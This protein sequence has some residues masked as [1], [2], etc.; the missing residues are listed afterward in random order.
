MADKHPKPTADEATKAKALS[1]WEGEGGAPSGRLEPKR[2]RVEEA[3]VSVRLPAEPLDRWRAA[4]PDNPTRSEAIRR[5]VEIGLETKQ[6]PRRKSAAEREV[7]AAFAKRA[8]ETEV[9]RRHGSS[10]QTNKAKAR[11]KRALTDRW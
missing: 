11:Q 5:L 10:D 2:P 7:G 9:D 3:V 6:P 1:R 8:A 4:Q